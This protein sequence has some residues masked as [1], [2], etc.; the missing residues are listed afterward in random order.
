MSVPLP[1][2]PLFRLTVPVCTST[3]P[4]LLKAQLMALAP[5]PADLRNVPALYIVKE[6]PQQL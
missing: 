6:P 5:V 4:V 3:R 2:P 1:V